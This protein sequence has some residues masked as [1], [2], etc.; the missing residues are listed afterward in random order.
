MGASFTASATPYVN[1]EFKG[2]IAW[3]ADGNHNDP[4]DWIASPMALAIFAEMGLRDR[5]VHFDYNCILPHTNSEWEKIHADSVLGA[6]K[7][8]GYTP[9]RFIDVRRDKDRAI[10][11]IARAINASSAD[12]PLYFV[13]A[14]PMEIPLLGIRK[15]DLTKRK[16]VYCISHSRW[17]E[18]YSPYYAFS[19]NKRSVIA[20]GVHWIQVQDQNRLLAFGR[21]GTPSSPEEF[22]PYFWLRDSEGPKLKFLW[23][24][25]RVSTRPDPSDAGM[26]WYLVTGDDEATP[27][28]IRQLIQNGRRPALV[29][30][31]PRIRLEA[32][33]FSQLEGY[34]LDHRNNDRT[35][36]HRISVALGKDESIG[37][38]RATFDALYV[39]AGRRYDVEI[40]YMDAAESSGQY[41]FFVNGQPQGKPWRSAGSGQGW[42]SHMIRDVEIA[43]GDELRID[44]EGRVARLD[45]VQLNP[46][47]TPPAPSTPAPGVAA[48][49]KASNRKAPASNAMAVVSGAENPIERNAMPLPLIDFSATGPLDD[50][51]AMPGGL[52]V[53][54]DAPGYL[55]LNGGPAVFLSGPDDPEAFLYLGT[56]QPDGT[57]QGGNQEEIIARLAANGV[58]AFHCQIFRMQ[59]CNFKH[60]GDDTHSPFIRHDPSQPLNEAVLAQWD[61][62]FTQLERA[63]IVLHFEFYNDATDVHLL[64][65]KLDTLGNLHPD[66]HRFITGI[67]NRFKHHKNILWGLEESANKLPRD[68]TAQFRKMAAVVAEA[69]NYNHPIVQSFVIPNDPEGDAFAGMAMPNDYEGDANVRVV[70]WLHLFPSGEDVDMYHRELARYG[71]TDGR[72]FIVMKN[73]TFYR[74]YLQQQPISRQYVWAAAMAGMHMLEAQH[75]AERTAHGH[76]LGDDGLLARF[77][78]QTDFW[79]MQTDNTRAHGATKWVRVNGNDSYIAY[80]FAATGP[81]GLKNVPAGKYDLLWFD[82]ESGR[83]VEQRG[84]ATTAAPNTSWPKPDGF[85]NE[86][87]IYIRRVAP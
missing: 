3:S 82:S 60:E 32:E 70:T 38:I 16:H 75:K 69:D 10:D 23:E 56:L 61:G 79:R 63:G 12:D 18:G 54:G 36:S 78:M 27:D 52:I 15:S 7:H 46:L 30:E 26:A 5:V 74:R 25:M 66:E 87:A 4:D 59:R 8:W 85:G 1:G 50:S 83:E 22:A 65:W 55:K 20:E 76:L 73:E 72:R 40:R 47:G 62:W 71:R 41:T 48:A 6:V 29:M 37:R 13:V 19:Y 33:N 57:R 51:A 84:V 77:M 39:P 35:A 2:R 14:G 58:T 67:V 43:P 86:V 31:Q 81:M 68:R 28:K 64:G 80:S 42:T 11:S 53:A 17:N 24:R 49:V 34:V 9:S 45:Y 21:F 44:A